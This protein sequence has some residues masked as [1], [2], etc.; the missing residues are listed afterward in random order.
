M[1]GLQADNPRQAE[2]NRLVGPVE[3]ERH[4]LGAGPLL[5]VVRRAVGEQPS[6]VDHQDAVGGLVGLLQVVGREQ[7]RLALGD[8]FLHLRPEPPPGLHVHRRGR[9]VE[10]DQVAFAGDRE[11]EPDALRLPAGQPVH[12]LVGDVRDAGPAQRG[13]DGNRPRVQ[14]GDERDQFADRHLRHQPAG[15]EHGADAAGLDRVIRVI[16]E[17]L[18]LPRRRLPQREEHVQRGGLAGAV[19][20]EQCDGFPRA[21]VEAQPVDRFQLTVVLADVL[22]RD[23]RSRSAVAHHCSPCGG[24]VW[25][26]A[27]ARAVPCQRRAPLT[28]H[29]LA[30]GRG[31]AL[32]QR[33]A[34][35]SV[36]GAL[37]VLAALGALGAPGGQRPAA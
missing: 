17:H 32:A 36:I 12:A 31:S 21:Q 1:P 26:Q 29:H 23:D 24:L 14:P 4:P 34:M 7:Q 9:L 3:A 11:R 19:R 6:P 33:P 18:D 37:G 5:D 20:A 27:M 8:L 16:A 15:L 2:Q 35:T 28:Y 30:D 25:A 10:H 13:V 22:E